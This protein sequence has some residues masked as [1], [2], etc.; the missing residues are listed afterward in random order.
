MNELIEL[1]DNLKKELDKSVEVKDIKKYNKIISKDR[2]LLDEVVKY[3]GTMNNDI[4]NKIIGN[5]NF[6]LYKEKETNLNF[7]ILDINSKLK[8]ISIKKDCFK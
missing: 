5:K 1:V 7:L 3:N 8:K 6:L 4:K 2:E